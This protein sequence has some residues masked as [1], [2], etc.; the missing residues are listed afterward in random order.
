MVGG[1]GGARFDWVAHFSS[2][3]PTLS[4]AATQSLVD[5][6]DGELG[7]SIPLYCVRP[8]AIQQYTLDPALCYAGACSALNPATCYASAMHV[9]YDLRS[10]LRHVSV[11]YTLLSSTR[12]RGCALGQQKSPPHARVK[13]VLG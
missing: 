5:S 11:S 4:L 7:V 10:L 8:D 13:R 2:T 9:P 6:Q 1:L 12:T 3:Q